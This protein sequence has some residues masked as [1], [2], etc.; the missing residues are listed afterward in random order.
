LILVR[1]TVMEIMNG[2]LFGILGGF[3]AELLGLF[4]VRQ[5]RPQDLPS[6]VRS[7]FYWVVTILMIAA[8][9]VLV[10]VYM[11]SGIDLKPIIAVNVGASA[12]LI[13]GTLVAQTPPLRID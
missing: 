4:R 13:I 7:P 11:K 2:F 12:P 3:L 9:G 1:F 5:Q 10:V 8:G 6:W